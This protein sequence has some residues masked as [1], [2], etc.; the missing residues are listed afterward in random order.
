M[1]RSVRLTGEGWIM[2]RV[3]RSAGLRMPGA[4]FYFFDVGH[5]CLKRQCFQRVCDRMRYDLRR[6][7]SGTGRVWTR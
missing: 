3:S 5:S 1:S 7:R 6:L 4:N 2:R